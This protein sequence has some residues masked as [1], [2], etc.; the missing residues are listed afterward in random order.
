MA[1]LER[2]PA[3][4]IIDNLKGVVDYYYWKGIPCCR[5]WPHWPKRQPHPDEKINQDAFAYV[6]RQVKHVPP[7]LRQQFQAMT[8]GTVLTWK[9][10]F[11][12]AYMAGIKQREPG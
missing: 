7:Y 6:N 3:Q 11:V 10:I 8:A 4:E 1:V 9:D 5:K 2:L 12:R